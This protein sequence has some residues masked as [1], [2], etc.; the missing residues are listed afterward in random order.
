MEKH[1]TKTPNGG[2][3]KDILTIEEGKKIE[4][5]PNVDGCRI[6]VEKLEDL[7]SPEFKAKHPNTI[8]IDVTGNNVKTPPEIKDGILP[9][10]EGNTF[11]TVG[12]AEFGAKGIVYVV[13]DGILQV[14]PKTPEDESQRIAREA[15]KREESAKRKYAENNP[16][17]P[18]TTGQGPDRS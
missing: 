16:E 15:V 1:D 14:I 18:E 17:K 7:T 13:I 12:A 11:E 8:F 3:N 10:E 4:N 2:S 5:N 9:G 6:V